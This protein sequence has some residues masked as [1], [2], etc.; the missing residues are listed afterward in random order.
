[1]ELISN[2]MTLEEFESTKV[3]FI[4][5]PTTN[6][7]RRVCLKATLDGSMNYLH[8]TQHVDEGDSR[9]KYLRRKHGYK[10]VI[11][12]KATELLEVVKN[13]DFVLEY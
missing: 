13:G 6:C 8:T 9:V 2:S 5:D 4:T 12:T 10:N 11:V 7:I 3:L 1:M